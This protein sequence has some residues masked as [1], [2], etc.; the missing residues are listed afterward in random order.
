[1]SKGREGGASLEAPTPNF[2]FVFFLLPSDPS[3]DHPPKAGDPSRHKTPQAQGSRAGTSPPPGQG[4]AKQ[5]TLQGRGR[6]QGRKSKGGFAQHPSPLKPPPFPR[7]ASTKCPSRIVLDPTCT[8]APLHSHVLPLSHSPT[9]TRYY[10]RSHAFTLFYTF[11]Q[12]FTRS[13]TI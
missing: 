7:E 5:G 11:L 4:T 6:G 3:R 8:L 1:M 12:A 9:L 10:T 13:S 2:L